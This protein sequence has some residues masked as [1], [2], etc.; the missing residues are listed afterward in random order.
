[1]AMTKKDQQQ[2]EVLITK[3]QVDRQQQETNKEN[4]PP[5][6]I[7]K[8]KRN[9]NEDELDDPYDVEGFK[10]IRKIGEGTYGV[11]FKAREIKTNEPVALK[12]LKMCAYEGV[13]TTTLREIAILKSL[14]HEN[15]IKL[16]D[17]IHKETKLFMVFEYADMDLRR[18]MDTMQ[19]PGLTKNHIKSFM[20]QLF[21]GIHYCHAHRVLHRDLKPQN[22]LI[23][24]QGRLMIAD[25]GLARSFNIPLRT[26][27]HNVVT[28]WYRAP[29]ILLG[30]PHYSTAV[31]M[32]S[33]GC[34]MAEMMTLSPLFPGASQIDA[35]FRI[36][37]QLGTPTEEVWP[38]VSALPDYNEHFP[39]FKGKDIRKSLERYKDCLDFSDTAYD[40]LKS[41][42]QY[43]PSLRI[44]AGKAEEHPF[45]YDDITMVK[46]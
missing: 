8:R 40:L 36:F 28:L 29:E 41:L 38:G 45:F 19:R 26:Y 42:L 6:K 11:V 23:D 35:L 21:K 20:H 2:T 37:E 44:S 10:K 15:I 14:N 5:P 27:T 34:I 31:D 16:K 4:G 1:M 22:L 30:S 24:R 18:Y 46:L 13:P 43:D 25:L 7:E 39:T 33:A 3:Q 9:V 12:K 17:L 32:W